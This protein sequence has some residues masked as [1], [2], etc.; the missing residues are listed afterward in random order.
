MPPAL[1]PPQLGEVRDYSSFWGSQQ[2]HEVVRMAN[3]LTYQ[4]YATVGA[5][6]AGSCGGEA[7]PLLRGSSG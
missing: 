6:A 2:W 1:L 7:W 3:W 5:S 4:N